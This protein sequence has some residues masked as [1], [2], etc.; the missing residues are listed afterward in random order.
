MKKMSIGLLFV[1]VL[2]AV[3]TAEVLP[4]VRVRVSSFQ[5]GTILPRNAVNGSGVLNDRHDSHPAGTMWYAQPY[6]P[7][8][9][10]WLEC[11]LGEICD[12]SWMKLYNYND[13]WS[14]IDNTDI[15]VQHFTIQLS[16]DGVNYTP[17][18][19]TRMATKAPGIPQ[20]PQV[21][22]DNRCMTVFDLTGAVA[23]F[24]KIDIIDNYG[25]SVAV[26]LSEVIFEGAYT[27]LCPNVSPEQITVAG[28][29]ILGGYD[30]QNIVNGN[31]FIAGGYGAHDWTDQS[32]G[33]GNNGWM[34]YFNDG[35][36]SL[37]FTFDEPKNLAAVR[38]WNLDSW[39]TGGGNNA[40]RDFELLVS[41][42]GVIFESEVVDEL[43]PYAQSTIHDYSQSFQMQAE[44]VLA[45]K[46]II[47][48]AQYATS[49]QTGLNE[50]QFVQATGP[51]IPLTLQSTTPDEHGHWY[52]TYDE[53]Y[54]VYD[55][56]LFDADDVVVDLSAHDRINFFIRPPAGY[57]MRVDESCSVSA[58]VSLYDTAWTSD[59]FSWN[60]LDG[61]AVLQGKDVPVTVSDDVGTKIDGTR[62]FSLY[63]G[64]D[65]SAGP[66]LFRSLIL[67]MDVSSLIDKS[68]TFSFGNDAGSFLLNEL[69][70][71]SMT[72]SATD[73]GVFTVLLADVDYDLTGFAKLAA[74]W[75]SAAGDFDYTETWDFVDDDAIDLADLAVFCENWLLGKD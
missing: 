29:S 57:L 37:T 45:V 71:S 27:G 42:D 18:G 60:A 14:D 36:V 31:G 55:R 75:D 41:T 5:G 38:I 48:S 10:A 51:I 63:Y 8:N 13:K 70:F 11:D 2:V 32:A 52:D 40:V 4:T 68:T 17:F 69:T 58:T 16:N 43:N 73:T 24:V 12:L 64:S 26:G 6:L 62:Q 28:S 50:I 53:T 30:P 20:D 72:E 39:W 46:M 34:G 23:R 22:R 7:V 33:S 67:S 25:S 54:R 21:P 49:P 59:P 61:T 66:W 15:G 47:T 3:S 19:G 35:Q 9:D 74:A 56:W 65:E 1:S 44:N